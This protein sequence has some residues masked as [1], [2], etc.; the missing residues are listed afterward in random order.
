MN[1]KQSI[2]IKSSFGSKNPSNYILNYTSREDATE[3][4]E[5]ENYITK[6]TT[7]LSANESLREEFSDSNDVEKNEQRLTNKEG[8]MFG[9]QGLSYS[10]AM[11]KDAAKTTQRATDEGHVPILQVISFDHEYLV[12][13]GI[14]KPDMKAPDEKGGYKNQIDQLKL[15]QGITDMMN[16]FHREMGF[17]QP[18]WGATI[19]LDTKHVHVHLTTVETGNPKEKRL[20]KV[21]QVLDEKQPRMKWMVEDKTSPVEVKRTM[22]GLIEYTRKDKTVAKQE[23]TKTGKPRWFTSKVKTDL[24]VEVEK[25]KINDKVKSIMRDSL[26]RSLS[27]TKDIRPFVKDITDKRTLTKS[28]TLDTLYYND[29]TVE[30][31]K[32]LIASLPENK[33]MWRAGSN[34]KAMKRS[35]ELAHEIIEDIWT[36]NRNAIGLNEF[37]VAT[38]TYAETRQYDEE[39]DDIKKNELISNGYERLKTESINLLYRHIKEE[40]SESDKNIEYPKYSI[41]AA[42]T[43]Q[44]QDEISKVDENSKQEPLHKLI[45]FEYRQRS[46]SDRYKKANAKQSYYKQEIDRYNRMESK[47]ETSKDSRVVK[48]FYKQE[49]NYNKNIRDKYA[50][51]Q[52]GEES[53]VSKERFDQIKGTDLV[54]MLYDYDNYDDRSVPKEVA[55]K[56]VLQTNDRREAIN[57]TLDYLV[58]TNQIEQYEILRK[59]RDDIRKEADIAHQINEELKLP[60]VTPSG[61]STIEKRKTIDTVQ[62]RRLLKQELYELQNKTKELTRDYNVDKEFKQ[63]KPKKLKKDD[64]SQNRDNLIKYQ[65]NIHQK[66]ANNKLMYY[67]YKDAAQEKQKKEQILK[68]MNVYNASKDRYSIDL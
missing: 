53:G 37:D 26:N 60:L 24:M 13:K 4:L 11:L 42:T 40:I 20:K 25:G 43:K 57:N 8:I 2:M 15:R 35:N 27:K 19:H 56:Y 17:N 63:Y 55:E 48:E 64:I 47:N 67:R 14:V 45:Q 29:A 65:N 16:R 32:V 49:Y 5:I 18:E 39:F 33:K 22:E 66:W 3:S 59:Y 41:K 68:D 44:L 9:S 28:L 34:A 23:I 50:Y 54:N 38:K 30:K 61:E 58:N 36:K 52:F 51:L 10:H 31:L 62:G 7:R 6:Y 12:E 46:Y 1:L 21:K